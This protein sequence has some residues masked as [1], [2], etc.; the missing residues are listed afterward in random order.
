VA[1]L[2]PYLWFVGAG[3]TLWR[4]L[5]HFAGRWRFNGSLYELLAWLFGDARPRQLAEDVWLAHGRAK[6]IGAVAVAGALAWAAWRRPSAPRAALG[7]T[8]VLLLVSSTVHPWYVTWLVALTALEFR[9]VWVAWS[10]LV[11]LAYAGARTGGMTGWLLGI[12]YLPV[13][14]LLIRTWLRRSVDRS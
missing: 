9:L 6:L 8:A 7:V 4:G 13:F 14:I 1:L 10:G 5:V 12:E 11:L 3:D 2:A